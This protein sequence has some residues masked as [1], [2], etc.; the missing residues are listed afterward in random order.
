MT[1]EA[2]EL[3]A[4]APGAIVALSMELHPGEANGTDEETDAVTAH[5]NDFILNFLGPQ[6]GRCPDSGQP[7]KYLVFPGKF[8]LQPPAIHR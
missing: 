3:D 1:D 7:A 8:P 6:P 2:D 4:Q 5:N